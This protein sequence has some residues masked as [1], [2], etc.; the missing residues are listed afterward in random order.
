[1]FILVLNAGSSSLKFQLIETDAEKIG[2]DTDRRLARGLVERIGS[3]ALIRF[4]NAAGKVMRTAQ[5]IGTHRAAIDLVLRWIVSPE[6]EIPGIRSLAD[7]NA[8]GHRVVHGGEKFKAS[9]LV[10]PEV[11]DGIEE[12][13]DL[14]PLHNPD[15]LKAIAAVTE[16]LGAGVP[17]AAVFDTAF[18][19][20]MPAT[21]YL[22]A[23][24]YQFYRR[25]R[26]RRYGFHGTSHRYIAYRYR[27][28]LGIDK[29]DVNVI[30]LHLGNG[31]SAA[32]IR[33][34]SSHDTSMG[35]T[36]LEG[37]VMGT[38]A[39][40]IDPAIIEHLMAKEGF[41][42]AQI[43]TL[44]NKSSGLLGISGLT[45][46]MRELLAE[47]AENGDRRATLAIEIF[48]A[49]I[50]K[51][52]GAYLATMNGADAILFAGGIGE[53]SAEIRA[54]ICHGMEWCGLGLDQEKNAATVGGIEGEISAPGSRLRAFVIPTDEELLI[55]RDTW[56]LVE[57]VAVPGFG[58]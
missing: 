14:A 4:E 42:I 6:A 2:S 37:L 9:T 13:I 34:G 40:D 16:I 48:V 57:K 41:S 15:N 8:V 5:P 47:E 46:D 20:S 7:I 35:M 55:A 54:R 11:I 27:R 31:C 18:H 24:P 1:M 50:R 39:G 30:S 3:Q 25:H 44:L 32:A 33:A 17:Q 43:D 38:R 29:K 45:N 12:C 56:R 10:T 22:Y 53:N 49:R 51:Y 19:H 52:I 23:L 58:V 36:P 21:S 28:I 26:V